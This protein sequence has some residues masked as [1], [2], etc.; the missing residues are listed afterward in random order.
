M[1]GQLVGEAWLFA[2]VLWSGLALGCLGLLMIGH[3]LGESWIHPVRDELEAGALTIPLAG[4]LGLPLLLA[5]ADLYPWAAAAELSHEVPEWRAAWLEPWFVLARNAGYFVLWT[6]LAL[7]VVRRGEHPAASAIG[8]VLLTPT[9]SLAGFDWILSREPAWWSGV[10]GLAFSVSQ[11][12]GALALTILIELLR[13]GGDPH[14]E[15]LRGLTK[16]LLALALVALWLWFAQ[17]LIVWSANLPHEVA[18][19]L[20]RGEQWAIVNWGVALPALALGLALLIPPHA[21]RRRIVA[22]GVLLLLNHVAYMAWLIRPPAPIPVLHWLDPL[23]LVVFG[24]LLGALFVHRLD[25][26]P[27]AQAY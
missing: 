17:F 23:A 10:F 3:L 21:G 24:L 15:H 26:R 25:R 2:F 9:V 6:V 11:L 27:G 1:T 14:P 18:W 7:L 4:L 12:L 13:P 16:A 22:S 5:L 8:L 20:R 19:Y